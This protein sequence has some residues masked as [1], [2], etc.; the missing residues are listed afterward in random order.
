MGGELYDKLDLDNDLSRGFVVSA[1]VL[2]E[3]VCRSAEEL[4]T[5]TYRRNWTGIVTVVARAYPHIPA[6]RSNV[7]DSINLNL[8]E[9]PVHNP[10]TIDV[11]LLGNG[12][13]GGLLSVLRGVSAEIW[14]RYGG[15]RGWLGWYIW[16]EE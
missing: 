2:P 14:S 4:D 7:R 9:P 11:L 5:F 12:H 3:A 6:K 8:H 1:S 13:C 15:V 16:A 10:G